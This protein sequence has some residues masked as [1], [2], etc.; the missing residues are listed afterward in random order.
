MLGIGLA[1]YDGWAGEPDYHWPPVQ[2]GVSQNI[3]FAFTH[4]LPEN[5]PGPETHYNFQITTP[6]L[7]SRGT[8]AG[9]AGFNRAYD[10]DLN[11]PAQQA[12]GS[13]RSPGGLLDEDLDRTFSRL[14]SL[15]D[16]ERLADFEIQFTPNLLNHLYV[17]KFKGERF[18][19]R[20]LKFS[21]KKFRPVVFIF[22]Y[23]T[24]L[25]QLR[26]NDLRNHRELVEETL[27]TLGLLIP[28][29][30]HSQE[31]FTERT[32]D[33]KVSPSSRFPLLEDPS[34]HSRE[35][36]R[37]HLATD[38][39]LDGGTTD[40]ADAIGRPSGALWPPPFSPLSLSSWL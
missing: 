19:W 32:P 16:M 25:D 8:I 27:S 28:Q 26:T 17:E 39:R 21:W 7:Q 9:L 35:G 36:V 31:W 20:S 13:I 23:A 14:F 40:A 4:F 22:Q 12:L 2:A 5:G 24:L 37:Q 30:E 18:S 6:A 11:T 3:N 33:G 10:L 1:G 34:S 29:D 38:P 15:R